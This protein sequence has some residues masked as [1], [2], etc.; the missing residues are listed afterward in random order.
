M[1]KKKSKRKTKKPSLFW[2]LTIICGAIFLILFTGAFTGN[3]LL[4]TNLIH[5]GISVHFRKPQ[6]FSCYLFDAFY[7]FFSWGA[8]IFVI[9]H[10]PELLQAIAA[11]LIYI[12]PIAAHILINTYGPWY[13]ESATDAIVMYIIFAIIVVPGVA[14]SGIQ[15]FMK[16]KKGNLQR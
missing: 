7:F 6:P 10:V 3:K 1:T 9:R 13:A 2:I 5:M 15:D 14:I 8:L 11:L 12:L 4:N 16:K